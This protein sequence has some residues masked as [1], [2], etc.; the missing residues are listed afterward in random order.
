MVY[1]YIYISYYISIDSIVFYSSW[2]IDGMNG[3]IMAMENTYKWRF[4]AG[5]SSI[6]GGVSITTFDYRRVTNLK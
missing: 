3:M 5:K 2:N 6:N 1:G 4:I